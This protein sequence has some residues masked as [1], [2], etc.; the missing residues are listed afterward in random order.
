MGT[1]CQ[2]AQIVI[3]FDSSSP[4]VMTTQGISNGSGTSP[5]ASLTGLEPAVASDPGALDELFTADS[6]FSVTARGSRPKT[7]I[8]SSSRIVAS[9]RSNIESGIG[10][11]LVPSS[12][13]CTE[14][15]KVVIVVKSDGLPWTFHG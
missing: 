4:S 14:S 11:V 5:G 7:S 1:V 10:L 12:R 6:A 9:E 3:T 2:G 15:E 13:D 8:A